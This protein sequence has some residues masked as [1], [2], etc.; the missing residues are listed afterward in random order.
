MEQMGPLLVFLGLQVIEFSETK[1]R[2]LSRPTLVTSAKLYLT[3]FAVFGAL[4]ALVAALLWPT[5]YFGPLSSRV[6]SLFVKHTRTGNP[7]V[8]SVAEHQPARSEAYDQYLHVAKNLAPFGFVLSMLRWTDASWFLV[9]WCFTTYF[10][11]TKMARLLFEGIH[12]VSGPLPQRQDNYTGRGW[13][14]MWGVCGLCSF[15]WL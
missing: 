8:D 12:P 3:N 11:S 1:R 4:L 15:G 7:L 10:F 5:G 9:C 14:E 2:Q 6:R 13:E